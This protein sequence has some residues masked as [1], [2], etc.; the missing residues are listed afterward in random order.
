MI[1]QKKI[2][3]ID[4]GNNH[5]NVGL[6]N[7][8]QL[9]ILSLADF[10]TH[11]NAEE[12]YF[13]VSE[14][15]IPPEEIGEIQEIPLREQFRMGQFLDMPVAYGK[16]LGDDRLYPAYQVFKNYHGIS[17]ILDL[18]TFLTIDFISH[19][20][21][22]LGGFIVP[23][24]DEFLA[25]FKRGRLLPD[26]KKEELTGSE[27]TPLPTNT[28]EAGLKGSQLYLQGLISRA[29]KLYPVTQVILTG[30]GL[31]YLQDNCQQL[32]LPPIIPCPN[33]LHQSLHFSA[34]CVMTNLS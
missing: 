16:S 27:L 15:G 2:A 10:L 4:I 1:K 32:E 17:M 30:G 23:G 9:E 26:L 28:V 12:F 18:G 6:L 33:L 21:G 7:K 22:F 8:D 20:K 3:S 11:Y 25:V 29:V 31:P 24:L 19:E 34:Q 13:A 5:T 14:V